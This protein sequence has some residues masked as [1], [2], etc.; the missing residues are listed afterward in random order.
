MLGRCAADPECSD[1]C[2]VACRDCDRPPAMSAIY[3][4][5]QCTVY[6]ILS[7]FVFF[8]RFQVLMLIKYYTIQLSFCFFKSSKKTV[9]KDSST[10]YYTSCFSTKIYSY[11]FSFSVLDLHTYFISSIEIWLL[12]FIILLFSHKIKFSDLSTAS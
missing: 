5:L 4:T 12:Y 1:C 2:A 10:V 7:I 9:F 8:D 3:S 6:I 11:F